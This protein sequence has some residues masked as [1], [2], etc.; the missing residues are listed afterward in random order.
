MYKDHTYEVIK[1]RMMNNMGIRIDKREGSFINNMCSG[2]AMEQAKSHMR[3]DDILSLGFIRTGFDDFLEWRTSESGIYRKLGKKA[4]GNVKVTGKDGI[5]LSNGTI[6]LCGEL[7]YV[8]LNDVVVNQGDNICYLEALEVGSNY[9]VLANS[10]FKLQDDISGIDSIS[11]ELDLKVVLILN[12]M[13]HYE[14]D[15]TSILMILLQVVM[16]HILK[17]GLLK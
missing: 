1:G 11:N 15:M 5:V 2:I 6:F 10:I 17:C 14:E 9:N 13:K 3:M 12:L 16:Q 4:T 7:A 8:M